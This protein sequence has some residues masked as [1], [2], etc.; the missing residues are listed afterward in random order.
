[1]KFSSQVVMHP[2]ALATEHL[3]QLEHSLQRAH[4]QTGKTRPNSVLCQT[5]HAH[6]CAFVPGR[7]ATPRH[8]TQPPYNLAT[9]VAT[10]GP[11]AELSPLLWSP[12]Y[13]CKTCD[14]SEI[15]RCDTQAPH[16]MLCFSLPPSPLPAPLP[17]LRS[18]TARPATRNG[19]AARAI[20]HNKR[21]RRQQPTK[22][23]TGNRHTDGCVDMFPVWELPLDLADLTGSNVGGMA[24]SGENG[25]RRVPNRTRIRRTRVRRLGRPYAAVWLRIPAAAACLSPE[26]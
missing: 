17:P 2:I 12:G 8:S 1:M 20:P 5:P 11:S 23:E 22:R 9:S 16:P 4:H 10:Q 14:G 6:H 21:T 18:Q 25:R 13:C 3:P 24:A 7:G 26:N 19:R 15:A